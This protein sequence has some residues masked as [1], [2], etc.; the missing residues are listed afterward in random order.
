[1]L[2]ES[3]V[4]VYD[5]RDQ[6]ALLGSQIWTDRCMQFRSSTRTKTLNDLYFNEEENPKLFT[7][8]GNWWIVTIYSQLDDPPSFFSF[9]NIVSE[10]FSKYVS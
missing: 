8:I 2:I 3:I 5:E 10:T 1:M 9:S 6:N 4:S 7:K